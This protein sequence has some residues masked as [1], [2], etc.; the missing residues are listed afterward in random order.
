LI[1]CGYLQRQGIITLEGVVAN[2]GHQARERAKLAKAILRLSGLPHVR[3]GVGTPGKPYDPYPHE[4]AVKGYEKVLDADLEDGHSLFVD[5][6]RKAAPKSLLVQG[7]S[8]LTDIAE[9]MKEDGKLFLEKVSIVSVQAGLETS[10]DSTLHRHGWAVD[11]SA[12]SAFDPPAAQAVIDFC[13]DNRLRLHAAGRLAVPGLPMALAN[14]YRDS[15]CEALRYLAVAQEQGLTG[16]WRRCC[17]GGYLPP[18]CDKQWFFSSFCG[19]D[20]ETF[21]EQNFSSLDINSDISKHLNGC[22]RPYD[23]VAFMSLL[24]GCAKAFDFQRAEVGI[25]GSK[26]FLF[27]K[28]EHAVSSDALIEFLTSAFTDVAKL[29]GSAD[30]TAKQS[31]L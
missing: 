11:S 6:L 9:V 28:E 8:G 23:L 30:G 15:G 25:N 17:E 27:I 7:Q 29:N 31:A 3:V 26:H 14:G 2:G 21:K 18:R 4:Y 19:V 16:L 1:A 10:T 5:V 12:N 22:V 13:F 20:S 24:P